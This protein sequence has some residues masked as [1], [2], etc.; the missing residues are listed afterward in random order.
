VPAL[1][2][3]LRPV[4]APEI[5][6]GHEWLHVDAPLTLAALRGRFVLLEFWTFC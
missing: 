2:R 1:Q 5:P 3:F 4:R 6:S